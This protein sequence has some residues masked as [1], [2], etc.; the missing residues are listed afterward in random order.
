MTHCTDS[1]ADITNRL[2]ALEETV[3]ED[4]KEFNELQQLRN[5]SFRNDITIVRSRNR[6]L[7]KQVLDLERRM[8]ELESLLLLHRPELFPPRTA[9]TKKEKSVSPEL[10]D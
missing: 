2:G 10:V 6:S 5:D 4:L 1:H 9:Q 3:D 7:G 8:D